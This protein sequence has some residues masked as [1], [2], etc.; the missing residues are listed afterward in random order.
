MDDLTETLPHTWRR[1]SGAI[2]IALDCAYG[3]NSNNLGQYPPTAAQIE[4][5]AQTIAAIADGLWLTIDKAHVMTHG[6]GRR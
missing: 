4:A 2:G 6:G 3:A 5:M 1:N